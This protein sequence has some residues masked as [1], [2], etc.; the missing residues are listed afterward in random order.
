[1]GLFYFD[2]EIQEYEQRLDYSPVIQHLEKRF[3]ETRD[4]KSLVTLI[5]SAWYYLI[6]GDVNQKPINYDWNYFL[7]KWKKYI[8]IGLEKYVNSTEVCYII[9]YT[10]SL[11]WMYLGEIFEQKGIELIKN[12]LTIKENE[13]ISMLAE[14]FL[15]KEK[16]KDSAVIN[17]LFPSKSEID[18][19]FRNVLNS[20][21]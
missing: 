5:A 16:L 1:M 18:T 12:C 2:K 7:S 9:G 11:H 4:I 8:A 20:K 19:Y 10:L 13:N 3:D 14:C 17:K 15:S 6:E 21:N